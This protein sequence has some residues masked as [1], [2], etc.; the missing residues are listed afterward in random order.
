MIYWT[1]CWNVLKSSPLGKPKVDVSSVS[2]SSMRLGTH[3]KNIC[4]LPFLLNPIQT[5]WPMEPAPISTFCNVKR[6][7]PFPLDRTLIHRN[8]A[9]RRL[10]SFTNPGR[11]KSWVSLGGKNGHTNIQ[12]SEKPGIE[13]GT[14]WMEGRDLIPTA[15]TTPPPLDNVWW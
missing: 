6:I 3:A 13:L 2:P 1:L 10:Y 8:L 4:Y 5:K 12:I 9:P 11:L 7:R 14:L 15:Q